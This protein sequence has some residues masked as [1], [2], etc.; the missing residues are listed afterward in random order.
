MC[1]ARFQVPRYTNRKIVKIPLFPV[2]KDSE[3]N[4]MLIWDGMFEYDNCCTTA[5]R[6]G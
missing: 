4:K 6:T 2:E 3:L 1:R 5:S